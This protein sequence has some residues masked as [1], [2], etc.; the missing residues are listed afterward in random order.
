MKRLSALILKILCAKG[1]GVQRHPTCSC[2]CFPEAS[3]EELLETLSPDVQPRGMLVWA[4]SGE[5]AEVAETV[6]RE[7]GLEREKGRVPRWLSRFKRSTHRLGSGH[8][9]AVL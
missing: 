6:S 8:D 1:A 5:E 4:L 9:L 3:S 7:A 2:G